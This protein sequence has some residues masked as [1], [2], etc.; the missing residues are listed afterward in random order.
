VKARNIANMSGRRPAGGGATAQKRSRSSLATRETPLVSAAS[1]SARPVCLGG[2]FLPINGMDFVGQ[3]VPK[4]LEILELLFNVK[5]EQDPKK[6]YSTITGQILRSH[7]VTERPYSVH[8]EVDSRTRKVLLSRC[9]CVTGETAK[10]KH[11][12]TSFMF[13]Y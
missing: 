1:S 11:G 2:A 12:K 9:S 13:R 6:D 8:F 7:S 5:E 10:C 3:N 4:G